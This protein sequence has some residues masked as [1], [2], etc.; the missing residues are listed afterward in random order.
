MMICILNF[1]EQLGQ[2]KTKKGFGLS[3]LVGKIYNAFYTIE[4]YYFFFFL[5]KTMHYKFCLC[6]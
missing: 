4:V 1:A 2:A 3:K 6:I 5:S